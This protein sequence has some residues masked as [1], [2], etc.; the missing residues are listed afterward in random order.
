[1]DVF[2]GDLE[3]IETSGLR[4]LNFCAELLTKIFGDNA[5][6]SCKEGQDMRNEVFFL[7]VK[8]LPVLDVL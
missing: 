3:T 8:F 7:L 6:R 5:I 2:H 1:M 4:D